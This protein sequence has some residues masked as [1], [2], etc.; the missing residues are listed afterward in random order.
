MTNNELYWILVKNKQVKP[1]IIAKWETMLETNYSAK[2]WNTIF[3]IPRVVKDTKLRAF[4]Y[5]IL[6]RLII[7]NYYLNKIGKST[8]DK[9]NKCD[10]VD[11]ITHFMWECNETNIFWV[12]F[13]DWWSKSTQE[14]IKITKNDTIFGL[15]NA[16]DSLNACVL[17]AKWFVY[18][19]KINSRNTNFFKFRCELKYRLAAEKIIAIN[20]NKL[21]QY[22]AIW[23]KI[24]Q[25]L[26]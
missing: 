18:R 5:K 2:E 21:I 9:C 7:C 26:L 15:L 1:I 6:F 11:N 10:K 8:T 14:K 25:D 12:Q 16:P 20:N 19:E 22:Q 3:S 4:Q 24:E 17:F 23:E 13:S